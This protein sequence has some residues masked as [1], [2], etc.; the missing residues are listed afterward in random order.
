M[1]LEEFLKLEESEQEEMLA[2][3]DADKNK[4]SDLEAEKNSFES[5]LNKLK[6]EYDLLKE[7]N[8]RTKELN[9]TL[10]RRL[11]V[12]SKKQDAESLL[13]EMFSKGGDL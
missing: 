3:Y 5:E 8:Q 1:K 2:A 7:E 10:G 6:E 11:N 12:E 13:H 9:F 4:V